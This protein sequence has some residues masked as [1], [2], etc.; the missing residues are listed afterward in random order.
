MNSYTNLLQA[1]FQSNMDSARVLIPKHTQRD[2]EMPSVSVVRPDRRA[3]RAT[4]SSYP[5]GLLT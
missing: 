4:N 3:G 2:Q 1:L 5:F